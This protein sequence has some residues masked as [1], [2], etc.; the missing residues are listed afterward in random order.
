M[1][2]L[3]PTIDI[4]EARYVFDSLDKHQLG[5]VVFDSVIELFKESRINLTPL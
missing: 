1:K 4:D 5:K 3:H 2:K